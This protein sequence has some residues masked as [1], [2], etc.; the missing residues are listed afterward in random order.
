M[1]NPIKNKKSTITIDENGVFTIQWFEDVTLEK[2]DI[3]TVVE[4]YN[5]MSQG[6]LWKV[7]H[8]LPGSTK[9]SNEGRNYAEK[10]ENP[11]LAEA[12][13]IDN[14]MHRKLFW[15]YRKYRSVNYPMREFSKIDDAYKWLE[16]YR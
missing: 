10:R 6:D 1:N 4:Q 13:V 5:E 12:F 2:E 14:M 16:K 11:A 15:F 9:V 3:K 7:L 8:L